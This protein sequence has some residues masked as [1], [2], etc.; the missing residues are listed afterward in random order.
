LFAKKIEEEEQ[1]HYIHQI[2]QLS[3]EEVASGIYG[4][5]VVR[6]KDTSR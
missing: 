4:K 1:N 5:A 2:L 6:A 3:E